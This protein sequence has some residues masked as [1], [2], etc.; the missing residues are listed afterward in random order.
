VASTQ[1]HASPL[2]SDQGVGSLWPHPHNIRLRA[3][4]AGKHPPIPQSEEKPARRLQKDKNLSFPYYYHV[5]KTNPKQHGK[6]RALAVRE[7]TWLHAGVLVVP[8]A[9]LAL[10]AAAVAPAATHLL[11]LWL[12]ALVSAA[13]CEEKAARLSAR[14]TL[15]QADQLYGSWMQDAGIIVLNNFPNP[16]PESCSNAVPRT[17]VSKA[18]QK[19]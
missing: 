9:V 17:R 3:H 13:D 6:W 4:L 11:P 18:K 19:P 2:E 14:T 12:L 15:S 8:A 5:K 16:F 10:P 7:R 1:T